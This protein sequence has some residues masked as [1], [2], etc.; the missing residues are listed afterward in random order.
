[1]A[2]QDI[3]VDFKELNGILNSFRKIENV[4]GPKRG[5][6]KIKQIVA[7]ASAPLKREMKN[8]APVHKSHPN[9][10]GKKYYWYQKKRFNYKSGTLKRSVGRWMGK[11][12]VFVAPRIGKLHNKVLGKPTFDG[13]YTHLA[14]APHKIKGGG[15]TSRHLNPHFVEKARIRKRADVLNNILT[16]ATKVIDN[17]YR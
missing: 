3:Y 15:K 14:I 12:G 13:W 2:S 11:T 1:M 17:N 16:G 6:R 9:F 8:I 5:Q 10:K 7:K 4:L